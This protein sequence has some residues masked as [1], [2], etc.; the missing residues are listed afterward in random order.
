[1]LHMSAVSMFQ[2]GRVENRRSGFSLPV[3]V[4]LG[5]RFTRRNPVWP[6]SVS[7]SR[8]SNRTGGVTASGSRKRLT[9]MRRLTP[10]ATS[11]HKTGV[12]RLVVNPRVLCRFLR[13]SLT[14]VPSLRRSYPA[15]S[16][17]RTPPLPQTARPGSRELPVDPNCDHRLG[18]PVLRLVPCV[19]MP[20]PLPRQV[21]WI[22]FA[23]TL[24]STSAFPRLQMGRHLHYQFRG[25]LSV[26]SCYN[27]QTCRVA[28]CDPLHR[29]LQRLRC[30]HR[31]S[32]C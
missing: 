2:R 32:D 23:R 10:S 7:C 3:A 17:L 13:P 15:S 9:P 20:S 29:R 27:L 1:D 25:L 12:A 21:R 4:G 30:L 5:F 11:E 14:G 19:C 8:S 16:V 18:L 24:P 22:R 31:C 26:H 28:L 6:G